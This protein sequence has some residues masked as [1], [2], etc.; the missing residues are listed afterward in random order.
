MPLSTARLKKVLNLSIWITLQ[1]SYKISVNSIAK[2]S[3]IFNSNLDIR[4]N[5][6]WNAISLNEEQDGALSVVNEY[7]TGMM[8]MQRTVAII[9]KTKMFSKMMQGM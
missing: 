3:Y 8:D 4:R 6:K 7:K 1:S 9:E 5:Y 2:V